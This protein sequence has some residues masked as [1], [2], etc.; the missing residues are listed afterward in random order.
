MSQF[1]LVNA[2]S[3]IPNVAGRY[4][5]ETMWHVDQDL[6]QVDQLPLAVAQGLQIMTKNLQS[7]Y[8]IHPAIVEAMGR[9]YIALGEVAASCAEIPKLFKQLHADDIRR[10]TAPRPGEHK[11]NV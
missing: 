11:W 3:E 6:E 1:P 9:M 2:A 4:W 8:P 7:A 10:K 5:P